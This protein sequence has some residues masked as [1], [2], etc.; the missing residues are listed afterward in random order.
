MDVIIS[1]LFMVREV[2]DVSIQ[3]IRRW[4]YKLGISNNRRDGRFKSSIIKELYYK[5]NLSK[6]AKFCVY[7]VTPN[8]LWLLLDIQYYES[9]R[10]TMD[11]SR[12]II[13][14]SKHVLLFCHHLLA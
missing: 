7:L 3:Q 8:I 12:S 11:N 6:A 14:S 2:A 9:S 1:F 5:V 10:F 4:G 13:I